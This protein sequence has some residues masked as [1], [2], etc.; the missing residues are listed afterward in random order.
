[1]SSTHRTR[2]T[3]ST[4]VTRTNPTK[5][6]ITPNPPDT[7]FQILKYKQQ[8]TILHSTPGFWPCI[9]RYQF[10]KMQGQ[11]TQTVTSTTAAGIVKLQHTQQ[12]MRFVPNS[13]NT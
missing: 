4:Q 12:F 11:F 9:S 2:H 5:S 8:T 3:H 6:S 10:R 7:D 13:R 1:M